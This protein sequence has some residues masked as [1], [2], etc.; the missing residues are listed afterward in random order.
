MELFGQPLDGQD[1]A[2]VA[3]L[4]ASVAFWSI[5]LR[6]H[7]RERREM[8][9]RQDELDASRAAPPPPPPSG[10]AAGPWG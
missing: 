5:V 9:R 10:G 3:L 6:N 4:L 2:R 7:M 1:V 8:K